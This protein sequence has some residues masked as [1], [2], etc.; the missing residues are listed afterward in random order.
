MRQRGGGWRPGIRARPRSPPAFRPIAS[1]SV[2]SSARRGSLALGPAYDEAHRRVRLGDGADLVVDEA[3]RETEADEVA[4][5]VRP[6]GLLFL[7][8][9]GDDPQAAR[10]GQP[11]AQ[12]PH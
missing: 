10:R 2:P 1:F 4:P 7:A 5:E 8:L 11:F 6:A 12:P 9:R 3:S